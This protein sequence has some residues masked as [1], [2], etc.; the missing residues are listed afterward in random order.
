[1][2]GKDNSVKVT[3]PVAQNDSVKCARYTDRV[4]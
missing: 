3:P 4:V 1:M 2:K